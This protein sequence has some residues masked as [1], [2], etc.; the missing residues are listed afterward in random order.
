MLLL[1][2]I[3]G[4]IIGSFLNVLIY[5]IPRRES[6][7][8][9]GSHCT[10][11]GHKLTAFE[12]VPLFS[13]LLLKGKCRYCRNEISS[14]YPAVELITAITFF[15]IMLK[16]GLT[17]WT[18]AGLILASILIVAAFTDITAGLIPDLLTYPGLIIGL[19]L[20]Y[21][22]IG[23]KLALIGS[24]GFALLF[25]LIVVVTKGGMGG[26]DVKLAAVMGAFLGPAG[27]FMVFVI[28]SLL[29]F[30]WVIPLLVKRKATR[31]TAIKFGPFLALAAISV[32]IYG[33]EILSLYLA[34]LG[35]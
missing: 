12:L 9:P 4:L 33:A 34:F 25:F 19:I 3:F 28:S 1:T 16:G 15:L 29:A 2:F 26:G 10:A 21:F 32:Y 5:R 27:S 24:I 17:V 31:K 13:F 14:L 7:I 23:V 22:T 11:C 20:S 35:I 30:M 6:V 18:V 8:W